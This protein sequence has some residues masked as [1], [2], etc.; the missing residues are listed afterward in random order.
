MEQEKEYMDAGMSPEQGAERAPEVDDAPRWLNRAVGGGRLSV[1]MLI[2][3]AFAL[4]ALVNFI[5]VV[6][7]IFK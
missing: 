1:G 5:V 6:V 7:N 3:L 2:L 4:Y